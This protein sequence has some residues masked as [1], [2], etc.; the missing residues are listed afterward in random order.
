MLAVDI[1]A[2]GRAEGGVRG[3]RTGI[4]QRPGGADDAHDG[5]HHHI[6]DTVVPTFLHY[7]IPLLAFGWL[8]AMTL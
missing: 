4:T 8:A 2:G 5:Q 3:G 6:W 7:N 1:Q